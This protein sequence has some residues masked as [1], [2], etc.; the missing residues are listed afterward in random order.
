MSI[1]VYTDGACKGNPGPGGWG[2]YIIHGSDEIELFDGNPNTTNNQMEMQAAIEALKY[3][4]EENQ[5]IDLYT[6]SNYL[7]QG[8]T[9]WIFNWKKNNW[10]T[11]SKKP[12]ANKDLWIEI[13]EL[14][15]V[16]AVNWHWVKGHDGDPGNERA[17]YL[18]NRGVDNVS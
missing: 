17:D 11:A 2:V 7:R 5:P 18:A 3:L 12:V 6:D 1:K 16:M 9:E 8:I 14:S 4:K 15:S 13:S 10:R